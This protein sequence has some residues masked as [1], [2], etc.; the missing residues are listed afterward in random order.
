M[1]NN[2]N[3][4]M[5][6]NINGRMQNN[7]QMND[8]MNNQ[9]NGNWQPQPQMMRPLK[10][11][12]DLKKKK[13]LI[14]G[15]SL[16]V[17]GVVLAIVVIVVLTMVMK[18]DY[19]ESYRVAKELKPKV[20]DIN[21]NY[22]CSRVIDYVSS[23]YTNEM[24]YNGYVEG[25]VTVTEGVDELVSQLGQTAGVKR[26][27]ELKAQ[28]E[29]FQEAIETV[30][31]DG[32][33]LK[34]RLEIYKIWHKFI[35]AADDL[36]ANSSS[37]AEIQNAAKVLTESGNEILAEYGTGWLE[38]TLAYVQ[39]YRTYS[40]T[41]YSASNKSEL[42]VERDN[43]QTERKNWI[44]ANEPDIKEIGGLSFENTSKMYTEFTKLY[45]MIT[46]MYEKNYDGSGD[47]TEF[48][49]EVFCG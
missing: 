28:Y 31:P 48:L 43:R 45:E 10:Q 27:K 34:Q 29:R 38:K 13:K 39:A 19:G 17:G 6:G 4:N 22:D 35:V 12:M 44:A 47:C 1:D 3:N 5:A 15:I 20:S 23:N 41:S 2:V 49:G 8:Q 14:L 30:M 37:D 24:T 36:S 21:N 42:R 33:E 46:E 25:C 16:G 11:V 32:G 9:G 18:V 7:G 40:N 26:N